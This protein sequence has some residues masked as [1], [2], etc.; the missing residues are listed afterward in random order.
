MTLPGITPA[1]ANETELMQR[2]MVVLSARGALVYR[3][4]IGFGVAQGGR[5]V[6]F[7][8]PGQADIGGMY[9][10]IA[11]EVETK[12]GR[13]GQ[14]PA[15]RNWQAAVERAG[16]VYVLARSVEDATRA[17]DAIDRRL[18]RAAA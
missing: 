10:G 17:L 11:L 15:Q 6:K 3:R 18:D 1:P 16:G 12:F 14:S 13:R 2:V 9:R 5:A 7:G 4:N 8:L